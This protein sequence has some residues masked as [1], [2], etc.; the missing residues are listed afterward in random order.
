MSFDTPVDR[1]VLEQ[2]GIQVKSIAKDDFGLDIPV[3]SVPLPS[4]GLIYSHPALKNKDYIEIKAMTAKE[5]EI[6][7]SRALIKNGTVINELL[8]SCIVDKSI[9]VSTLTSGDRT[10]LLI[11]LRITGYGSDYPVNIKCEKCSEE[12]ENTFNLADLEIKRL[13]TQPSEEFKNIFDLFLP[14]TKKTIKV[15][16]IDGN[17][18]ISISKTIEK[19]KKAGS[20]IDTSLTEKLLHSIVSVDGIEDKTKLLVFIK[21]MPARDSLTIRTFLENNEPTIKMSCPSTCIHCNEESEVNIPLGARF[22]WPNTRT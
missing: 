11:A 10:A 20:M 22:F 21:N 2:K 7:T 6:L 3:E 12:Y 8:K 14:V 5:E 18:E 17:D 15:R 16:F 19:R 1:N 13:Q 4:E 9:D